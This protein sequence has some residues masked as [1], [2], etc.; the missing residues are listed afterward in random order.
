LTHATFRPGILDDLK[1]VASAE[2]VFD[3]LE[4]RYDP[5]VLNVARLHILKRIG[6][7]LEAEDLEGLPDLAVAERCK[8]ALQ[9][10]YQSFER[11]SPRNG[12]SFKVFRDAI[13]L[14]RRAFVPFAEL[15]E[16]RPADT[17]R[18]APPGQCRQG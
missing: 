16:P 14:R 15:L 13:A 9:R 2:E 5:R 18:S 10:V 1:A 6:E 4:V 11:A 7:W 8:A 17:S 3:L 12:A